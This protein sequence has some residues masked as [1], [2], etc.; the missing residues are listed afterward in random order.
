MH[1]PVHRMRITPLDGARSAELDYASTSRIA[2]VSLN[3]IRFALPKRFVV[4]FSIALG[5][6][7]SVACSLTIF[8]LGAHTRL[9][10][11]N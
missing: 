4:T 10:R 2:V 3:C 1:K 5:A 8:L 11:S 7:K 6:A 9:V